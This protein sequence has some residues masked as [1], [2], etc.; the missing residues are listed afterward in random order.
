MQQPLWLIK[1]KQR[2]FNPIHGVFSLH[3]E[4]PVKRNQIPHAKQRRG[5]RQPHLLSGVA[6]GKLAAR[7]QLAAQMVEMERLGEKPLSDSSSE[8]GRGHLGVA[9][10]ETLS[11]PS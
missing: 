4:Q 7:E 11:H 10:R 3:R 8:P 5:R 9:G 2:A 1:S 6:S